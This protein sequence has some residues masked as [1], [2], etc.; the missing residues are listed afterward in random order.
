M[1]CFEYYLDEDVQ[2]KMGEENGIFFDVE[3]IEIICF[4]TGI[5]FL[6]L[7]THIDGTE[8][9]SDILDFNYRFKTL[10]SEFSNLKDYKNTN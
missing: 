2:G 10:C 9:F 3:K 6:S 5:C 4:K 8:S 7:K 1:T